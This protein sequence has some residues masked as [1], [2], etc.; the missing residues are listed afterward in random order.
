MDHPAMNSVY[1]DGR[2][3]TFEHVHL[4]VAAALDEGLAVPVIR[5]AER[6][7]LIELA[8]KS[9]VR[10]KAREGRLLHDE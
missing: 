1:Q 3:A 7:P 8:K 9:M 10:Q 5:H 6:L 4:G 2:L